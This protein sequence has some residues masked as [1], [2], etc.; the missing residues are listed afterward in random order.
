MFKNHWSSCSLHSGPARWPMPCDCLGDRRKESARYWAPLQP[1]PEVVDGPIARLHHLWK[2]RF[3]FK[4]ENHMT[5][6]EFIKT[7]WRGKYK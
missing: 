7:I 1:D 5:A 6:I 3:L 2:A 4:R